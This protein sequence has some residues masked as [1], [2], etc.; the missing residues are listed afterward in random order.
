MKT[1]TLYAHSET[2]VTID[3][4]EWGQGDTPLLI[5]GLASLFK[6][7]NVLPKRFAQWFHCYFFDHMQDH[8]YPKP[9]T[10]ITLND[11]VDEV[12]TA[13]RSLNL[14]QF[15]LFVH[16]SIS[17]IGHKYTEC[18]PQHVKTLIMVGAAPRWDDYKQYKAQEYYVLNASRPRKEQ[19]ARDKV[20]LAALL[21]QAGQQTSPFI[22][23]YHANRTH[24]FADYLRYH[25]SLWDDIVINET[26]IH[27]FF[28]QIISGYQPIIA[29]P[30]P[31]LVA[32][33]L[34]DYRV[35]FVLW[36]D[37][38]F[39]YTEDCG[40]GKI[41]IHLFEDSGHYAMTEQ[42]EEFCNVLEKFMK[43]NRLSLTHTV[44]P[45]VLQIQR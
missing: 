14:Q 38:N 41:H 30:V 23:N 39:N 22:L 26:F 33:G 29:S 37:K 18:Y 35:P 13:R 36:T 15:V 12:E 25:A 9:I 40:H 45:A 24:Y 2:P 32:L 19:A 27:H 17:I 6:K 44:T 20:S 1:V 5:I 8:P 3:V 31:T 4:H 21:N 16:S 42:P 34:H 28:T 7:P 11:L 43:R 10:E